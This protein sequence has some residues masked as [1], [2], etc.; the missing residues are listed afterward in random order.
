MPGEVVLSCVLGVVFGVV[1]WY[2]ARRRP[3]R[4]LSRA[5]EGR[6]L[7]AEGHTV[8]SAPPEQ[9]SLNDDDS[10]TAT[11]LAWYR[12]E[13][14]ERRLDEMRGVLEPLI[15]HRYSVELASLRRLH[16]EIQECCL[17][18]PSSSLVRPMIQRLGKRL[19]GF[20]DSLDRYMNQ[21]AHTDNEPP[22]AA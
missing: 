8:T 22:P 7:A 6:V 1:I 12:L 4:I 18:D 20:E 5:S 11:V 14:A 16:V 17:R 13:F 10:Y 2:G 19:D 9:A 15:A 3:T 21:Y